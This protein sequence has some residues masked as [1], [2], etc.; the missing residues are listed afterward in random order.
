LTLER[1]RY[2]AKLARRRFVAVDPENRLV[3]RT[4]QR[5]WNERLAEIERMERDQNLCPRLASRL[6]DPEERCRLLAL[7][8]DLSKAWHASTTP[9]AARKQLLVYL[10]KDVTFSR[11]ETLIHVAIRWQ[12]EACTALEVPR[13]KRSCEVRRTEP[14]VIARIR[15]LT[16]DHT[17][18]QIAAILAEEGLRSGTHGV[19]TAKKVQRI[20]HAYSL[21]SGCPEGPA[22]CQK[23]YGGDRRC[24]AQV[25]AEQLNVT[26][27]T[28]ADWCKSGRLDGI[29]AVPHGPWWI[30]LTPGIIA[31]LRKPIRRHWSRRSND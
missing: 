14:A 1:A 20:R 3:A 24:T 19:L 15:V 23:G 31:E 10:I 21:T 27:Y 8:Q 25:A 17:Y 29:Q 5:E 4:L 12:T 11:G 28:I 6:V 30:R 16:P 13:P 2:E 22:A 7:A 26:V 18:S 9:Q